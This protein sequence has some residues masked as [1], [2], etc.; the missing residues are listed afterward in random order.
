MPRC[1]KPGS[2]TMPYTPTVV[3]EIE[4]TPNAQM[5]K[6]LPQTGRPSGAASGS[7]GAVAVGCGVGDGV[8]NV[9]RE[10]SARHKTRQVRGG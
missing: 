9:K 6:A 5:A 8:N 10:P 3:N 1:E 2:G 4:V 7:D